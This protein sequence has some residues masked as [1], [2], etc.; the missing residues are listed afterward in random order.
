MF[1]LY[2][3]FQRVPHSAA[4]LYPSC[5][6]ATF[7]LNDS[8]CAEDVAACYRLFTNLLKRL[9]QSPA[10]VLMHSWGTYANFV[11]NSFK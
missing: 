8:R 11:Y 7:R 1:V 5:Q 2:S 10:S 6:A 3:C 9:S 4:G